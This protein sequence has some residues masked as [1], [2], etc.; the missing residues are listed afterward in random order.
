MILRIAGL[1]LLI[2]AACV[3]EAV[4]WRTSGVGDRWV[5][6]GHKAQVSDP[7]AKGPEIF[8]L[9][10]RG[11]LL[12]KSWTDDCDMSNEQLGFDSKFELS[13]SGK[14]RGWANYLIR[15]KLLVGMYPHC[16]PAEEV[17][18]EQDAESHLRA[19]LDSGVDCF[20]CVQSEAPPQTDD[21]AW[22]AADMPSRGVR[23]APAAAEM[24]E[25]MGLAVDDA[26]PLNFLHCPIDA[27]RTP[28]DGLAQNATILQL[29]DDLLSHYEAGGRCV[30]IHSALGTG[31]AAVVGACL[32]SLLRPELDAKAVLAVVRAG[33]ET[34]GGDDNTPTPENVLQSR[35]VG[36]FVSA[37][38]AAKR[39]QND[40][41]M[42]IGGLPKAFL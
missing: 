31:R 24:A 42:V 6:D 25:Q 4:R 28:R 38:R 10:R 5:T 12:S 33:Y 30:Y 8:T 16:W 36:S 39:L 3:A 19:L 35:F 7:S 34:R 15:G 32:L 23:Y 2:Q 22:E 13:G 9:A 37:V 40:M 26:P 14:C 11:V 1:A 17:R 20:A 27:K 29:L 18:S 41:D 21:L